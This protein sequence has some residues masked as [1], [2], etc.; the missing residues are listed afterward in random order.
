METMHKKMDVSIVKLR[1]IGSAT[2]LSTLQC[3]FISAN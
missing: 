2:I 3:A 1:R